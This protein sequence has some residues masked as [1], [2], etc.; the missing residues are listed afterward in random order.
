[1]FDLR[2]LLSGDVEL[3]PGPVLFSININSLRNKI[4]NLAAEL[5]TDIDIL[6]ISETRLD[7]TIADTDIL[8]HGFTHVFRKDYTIASGGVCLQLSGNL[9]G[10]RLN[11]MEQ[12]DLELLWVKVIL[13]HD[14]YIIGVCYRNPALLVDYWDKLLENVSNVVAI[15]GCQVPPI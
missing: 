14:Y 9:V 7:D 4:D 10:T 1:M 11:G 3:N 6:C 8:V 15:Y 5:E 2:I 13:E 12:P